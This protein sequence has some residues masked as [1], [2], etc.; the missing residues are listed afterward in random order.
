MDIASREKL[1]PQNYEQFAINLNIWNQLALDTQ[2]DV[3]Q[4]LRAYDLYRNGRF[5]SRKWHNVIERHREMLPKFRKLMDFREQNRLIESYE[6][7]RQRI[8]EMN[9]AERRIK[10]IRRNLM[11]SYVLLSILSFIAILLAQPISA[12][13]FAAKVLLLTAT[14]LMRVTYKNIVRDDD[15][16]W[17][18]GRTYSINPKPLKYVWTVYLVARSLIFVGFAV[19]VRL[20]N[21]SANTFFPT[22]LT[23]L[24]L[25]EGAYLINLIINAC[26]F[27]YWLSSK[28]MKIVEKLRPELREAFVY[29]NE[30]WKLPNGHL[31]AHVNNHVWSLVILHFAKRLL[32]KSYIFVYHRKL[33]SKTSDSIAIKRNVWNCLAL[34]IQLDVFQCLR[35]YD[36]YRNGRFV[37]RQWYNVIEQHKG[38]LPKFRKLMDCSEQNRLIEINEECRQRRYDMWKAEERAKRIR[39]NLIWTYL[40]LG[41]LNFIAILLAQPISAEQIAAKLFESNDECRQR[42]YEM[43]QKIGKAVERTDRIR[44]SLTWTYLLLIILNFIAILFAQPIS[45]EKIAANA[46][47]LTATLRMFETYDKIVDKRKKLMTQISDSIAVKRNIWNQLALD[48][49]LDVFQCLRAYD[50]YRNGRFASRQWYNVIQQ[51]KGMLPKFRKLMDC[52]EQNMLSADKTTLLGTGSGVVLSDLG[53]SD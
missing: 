44:R 6:E 45:A 35:A 50:L 7:C 38:M 20:Y 13:Q 4:C 1:M 19:L 48:I 21:L 17:I 33:M 24:Y 26:R 29:E 32:N 39:R 52:S 40:L 8:Y 31:P 3:F 27:S 43:S 9:R 51:H 16:F 18:C 5:V 46:L 30:K 47:L 41:V 2:L 36:L 11:R 37:S 14:L 34:D 22:I 12:E 15:D 23:I 28:Y 25:P 53:L 49:Q 10:S 42:H